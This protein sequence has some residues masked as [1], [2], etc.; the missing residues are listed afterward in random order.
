MFSI[1]LLSNLTMGRYLPL[2]HIYLQTILDNKPVVQPL[3][4]LDKRTILNGSTQKQQVLTQW[5]GLPPAMKERR[6]R[7][8]ISSHPN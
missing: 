7:A 4:I 1:F 8:K 2:Y 3:A 5:N 6:S